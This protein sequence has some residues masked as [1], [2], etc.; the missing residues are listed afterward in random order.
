MKIKSAWF[1]SAVLLLGLTALSVS[2]AFIEPPLPT[3]PV[4]TIVPPF[5]PHLLEG[6]ADC[7]MCHATGVGGA[8]QFPVA[9]HSQRPSDVCLTCHRPK[10]GL[11][12]DNAAIPMPM[13]VPPAETTRPSGTTTPATTTP[14][15]TSANDLFASKCAA[16]HGVNRQGI[17]GFAPALTP[18]SLAKL[19]DAELKKVIS[20][21]RAGTAMPAFK[22]SLSTEQIDT[23]VKFIKAPLP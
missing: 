13:P 10:P 8:P 6:R 7:R 18:D 4:A 22:E 5:I 3:L 16:C 12:A 2:C 14:A 19:S 9:D 21:G 23:T 20:D 1:F 11:Y 15:P 17:P